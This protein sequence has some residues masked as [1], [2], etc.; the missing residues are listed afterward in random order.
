MSPASRLVLVWIIVVALLSGCVA[1]GAPA[2]EPGSVTSHPTPSIGDQATLAPTPAKLSPDQLW[3]SL[4]DGDPDFAAYPSIRALVSDATAVVVARME[5]ISE[6]PPYRD[7][8][9]NLMFRAAA[10][11]D[12]EATLHGSVNARSP[13]VVSVQVVL[14]DQFAGHEPDAWGALL[15]SLQTSVVKERAILFLID[16]ETD[17]ERANAQ[18]NP[19]APDPRL[20]LMFA[21]NGFIRDDNGVARTSILTT[22]A[23]TDAID[24]RPFE[25]V[26][27]EVAATKPAD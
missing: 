18:E 11:L 15:A 27:A 20:Y 7:R 22:K 5:S 6:A 2:T 16:E 8:Y 1:A 14:G 10:A 23:W 4:F 17:W 25:E 26:V 19:T 24:G 12:V 21:S 9:G 3:A 13:G